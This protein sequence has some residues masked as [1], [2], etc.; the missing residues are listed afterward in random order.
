MT[1]LRAEVNGNCLG[2][3]DREREI[4][5]LARNRAKRMR[6]EKT[7]RREFSSASSEAALQLGPL[8]LSEWVGEKARGVTS[9][10]SHGLSPPLPTATSTLVT[11]H[12][13]PALH[14]HTHPSSRHPG[15]EGR[16]T[17]RESLVVRL[18]SWV[19]SSLKQKIHP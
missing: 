15:R 13:T 4:W 11:G 2:E 18:S 3:G 17:E 8:P 7:G 9:G 1:L 14:S 19:T 12:Q 16:S 6:S 5:D 10:L